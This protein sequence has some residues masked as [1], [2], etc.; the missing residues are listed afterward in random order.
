MEEIDGELIEVKKLS[1]Q[2]FVDQQH[3]IKY[4]TATANGIP[5]SL[6]VSS[7]EFLDKRDAVLDIGA[8]A[9]DDT[10]FLLDQGFRTVIAVD[11]TP[12]FK[13]P[14]VAIGIQF[15]Y[16]EE[17]FENYEIPREKFDLISAQYSLAFTAP[18][19]FAE[20]WKNIRAGLKPNGVFVGQFF[21]D[22]DQWSPN[23]EMSFQSKSEVQKLISE[24]EILYFVESE[25]Q[26]NNTRKKRWHYFDVIAKKRSQ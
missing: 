5:R 22:R 19:H 10:Q 1:N 15:S 2:S 23:K 11:Q 18:T 26:E 25:F 20:F 17:K 21:G 9:L 13:E 3:W 8:G 16:I 24:M 7:L 14:S 4:Q 6:L 12:Q